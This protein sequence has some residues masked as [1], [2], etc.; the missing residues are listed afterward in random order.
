M[1]EKKEYDQIDEEEGT[2]LMGHG[3]C[4]WQG[5]RRPVKTFIFLFLRKAIRRA[6]LIIK[7]T[8]IISEFRE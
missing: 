2:W 6:L 5:E 7:H 4:C 3:P 8:Y 1:V